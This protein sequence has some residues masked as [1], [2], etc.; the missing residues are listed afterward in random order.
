M[1]RSPFKRKARK[2]KYGN[3]SCTSGLLKRKFDS[4]GECRY[5]EHLY[6]RQCNGEIEDLQ[7]Q[8]RW[9]CRV[10]GVRIGQRYMRI[11]F[12]YF[13]KHLGEYV[14]DDFKGLV[15]P[16]WALKADLWRAD[17]PGLLRITKARRNKL[18]PYFTE[19]IRPMTGAQDFDGPAAEGQDNA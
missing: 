18:T 3:E 17:G 7:F 19:E 12:R 2:S 15:M 4:K 8:V 9:D 5:A 1:K 14:W 10:R 11:D 6:A 13:D 16:E